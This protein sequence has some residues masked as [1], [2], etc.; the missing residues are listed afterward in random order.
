M[1][2]TTP[3][4]DRKIKAVFTVRELMSWIVALLILIFLLCFTL[5]KL[6]LG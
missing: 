2:K 6:Y 3:Y 4:A 1:N 5:F